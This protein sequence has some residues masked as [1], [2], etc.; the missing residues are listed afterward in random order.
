MIS[1]ITT[2]FTTILPH[3]DAF[4]VILN[5]WLHTINVTAARD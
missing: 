1:N 5:T 4:A 3:K 2:I